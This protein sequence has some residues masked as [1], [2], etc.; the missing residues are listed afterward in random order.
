MRCPLSD[1]VIHCVLRRRF[2]EGDNLFGLVCVIIYGYVFRYYIYI[3]TYGCFG[4]EYM[5]VIAR[6]LPLCS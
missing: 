6:F 4:L 2:F 1:R 3:C 5:S